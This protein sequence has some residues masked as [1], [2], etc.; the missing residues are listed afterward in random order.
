[1]FLIQ[2]TCGPTKDQQRP[3]GGRAP[4]VW[5]PLVYTKYCVH[6]IGAGLAQAV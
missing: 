2:T 6:I 4:T 5:K 1:M 3:P